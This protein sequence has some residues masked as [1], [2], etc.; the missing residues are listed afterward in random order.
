MLD[1]YNLAARNFDLQILDFD[2]EL[3]ELDK[4]TPKLAL[5]M[6]SRSNFGKSLSMC[7]GKSTRK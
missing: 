1:E 3:A 4:F 7:T 5:R 6:P 2:K